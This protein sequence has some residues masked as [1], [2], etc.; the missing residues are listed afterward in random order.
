MSSVSIHSIYSI[1]TI[2]NVVELYSFFGCF[3]PHQ[4]SQLSLYGH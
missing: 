4:Y 1:F 3:F 2:E